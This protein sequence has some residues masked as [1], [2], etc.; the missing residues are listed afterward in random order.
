MFDLPEREPVLAAELKSWG[1]NHRDATGIAIREFAT[2]TVLRIESRSVDDLE[3]AVK[4]VPTLNSFRTA[5][6]VIVCRTGP[7]VVLAISDGLT[8]PEV[9]EAVGVAD[10]LSMTDISHG[11]V[12]LA[13]AGAGVRPVLSGLATTDLRP[14][15]F[16]PGGCVR[17]TLARHTAQ[18][19]CLDVEHFEIQMDRS[20]CL[21]LWQRLEVALKRSAWSV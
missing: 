8:P 17:T 16:L 14:G 9:A 4:P 7:A 10:Q 20:L 13:L 3:R 12:T 19:R 5:D 18:I 6:G 1:D 15:R 21:S 2:R 11:F